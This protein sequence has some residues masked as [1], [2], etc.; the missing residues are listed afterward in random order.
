M[1]GADDGGVAGAGFG[2]QFD[3]GSVEQLFGGHFAE[4]AA[5][6]LGCRGQVVPVFADAG[7]EIGDALIS[8]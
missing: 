4:E 8:R 6:L 1:Q 7:A 3:G 5:D 2:P